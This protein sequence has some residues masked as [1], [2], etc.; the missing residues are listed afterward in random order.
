MADVAVTVAGA[1]VCSDGLI[2]GIP[3]VVV[4]GLGCL[5]HS[6]CDCHGLGVERRRQRTL[7]VGHVAALVGQGILVCK[8]LSAAAAVAVSCG[9]SGG[10]GGGADC[11]EWGHV[12]EGVV[13]RAAREKHLQVSVFAMLE[14]KY[15]LLCE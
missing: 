3:A 11:G 15:M 7:G 6:C 9:G 2:R 12:L 10:G 8:D 13:V 1:G 14:K 4:I 5:Y